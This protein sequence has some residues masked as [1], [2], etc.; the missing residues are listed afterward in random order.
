VSRQIDLEKVILKLI[1][2]LRLIINEKKIASY[3]CRG[4]TSVNI[5]KFN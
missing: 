5:Q 3:F 1:N 2:N 4:A